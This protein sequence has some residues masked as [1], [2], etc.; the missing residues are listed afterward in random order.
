M[1]VGGRKVASVTYRLPVSWQEI[2][3]IYM[4]DKQQE[5]VVGTTR[6]GTLMTQLLKRAGVTD[7]QYS[8]ASPDIRLTVNADRVESVLFWQG[9]EGVINRYLEQEVQS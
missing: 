9:I 7:V 2:D 8:M 3:K 4:L 6:T 5:R 1:E